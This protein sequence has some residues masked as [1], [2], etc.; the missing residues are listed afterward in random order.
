MYF[1]FYRFTGRDHHS[2][3]LGWDASTLT[4]FQRLI[5]VKVLR[6]E[7]LVES[8]RLFVKEQMGSKFVTSVGFDL[9]EI[10]DESDSRKPLIFILSPGNCCKVNLLRLSFVSLKN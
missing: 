9:Q 1:I 10:F 5:S 4:S 7:C 8:V 3:H 2:P 6:P